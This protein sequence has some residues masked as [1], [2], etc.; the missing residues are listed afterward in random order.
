MKNNNNPLGG[1]QALMVAVVVA[2]I[3]WTLIFILAVG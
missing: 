2:A 3:L 1:C